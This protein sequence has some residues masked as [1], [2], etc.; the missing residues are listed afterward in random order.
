MII[1]DS[2]EI[3]FY[4]HY[5]CVTLLKYDTQHNYWCEC[6]FLNDLVVLLCVAFPVVCYWY[7]CGCLFSIEVFCLLQDLFRITNNLV[8]QWNK[9]LNTRNVLEQTISVITLLFQ[10]R[11]N[12][13]NQKETLHTNQLVSPSDVGFMGVLLYTSSDTKLFYLF[14]KV[15]L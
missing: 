4:T 11:N 6:V 2:W 14:L 9:S 5:K 15:M 3:S 12:P 7:N 13:V 8:K 1:C 10:I